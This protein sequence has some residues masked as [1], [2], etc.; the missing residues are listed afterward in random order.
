VVRAV[1]VPVMTPVV[2]MVVVT[3]ALVMSVVPCGVIGPVARL[4]DTGSADHDCARHAEQC[5]RP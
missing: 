1:V 5:D 4:R 2:M 3:L